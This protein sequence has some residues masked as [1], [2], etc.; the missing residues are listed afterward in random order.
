M[1]RLIIPDIWWSFPYKDDHI[2]EGWP[3][4]AGVIIKAAQGIEDYTTRTR[5]KELWA[6]IVDKFDLLGNFHYLKTQVSG[7][8]QAE[9][10]LDILGRFPRFGIVGADFER[11]GNDINA[12]TTKILFDYVETLTK[13]ANINVPIYANYEIFKLIE[14]WYPGALKE[15]KIWYA[16]GDYYNTAPEKPLPDDVWPVLPPGVTMNNLVLWQA[17][18]D[19]DYLA[20]EL[21]FG[22][23]ENTSI[24][25]NYFNGTLKEA[26]Q[27]FG[28]P[29]P[30]KAEFLDQLTRLKRRLSWIK[31]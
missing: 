1:S 3:K 27:F 10:M 24:D 25:I 4:P 26:Y 31:G 12:K 11:T 21:D 16:G 22:T 14:V 15:Y 20:D 7:N 13:F 29:V 2:F 28:R 9:V 5:F 19:R 18:A 6:S 8:A 30:L 23:D 17:H